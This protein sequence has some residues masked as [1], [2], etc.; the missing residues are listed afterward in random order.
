MTAR[1]K[2]AVGGMLADPTRYRASAMCGHVIVGGKLCGYAGDCEHQRKPEP[3]AAKPVML[4]LQRH[5][6][7]S[8]NRARFVKSKTPVAQAGQTLRRCLGCGAD[9]AYNADG[10]PDGGALPCVD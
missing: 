2:C 8:V 10:T 6:R 3:E 7:F 1:P 4:D 9:H 5:S